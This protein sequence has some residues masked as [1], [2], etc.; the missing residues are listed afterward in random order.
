MLYLIALKV[1][2]EFNQYIVW[3]VLHETLLARKERV[4]VWELEKRC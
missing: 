3:C 4:P 1:T 2:D